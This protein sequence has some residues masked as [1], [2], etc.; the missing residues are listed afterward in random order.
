VSLRPAIAR[1]SRRQEAERRDFALH[2]S[3]ALQPARAT[4]ACP[5]RG[6]KRR[7]P[8]MRSSFVLAIAICAVACTEELAAASY[9]PEEGDLVFQSAPHAPLVDAI[10]GA[11][12]SRW[13]HCGIVVREGDGWAVIEAGNVVRVT[14]FA[15]WVRQARDDE[16]AAYRLRERPEARIAAFIEAAKRFL[17]RPYDARYRMDDEK[18]YCSELVEKAFRAATGRPLGKP[19]RLGDMRWKPYE[20]LIRDLEGGGLPLD[21]EIVSPRALTE[22]PEVTKVY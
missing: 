4:Y 18:I 19:Q 17:G 5:T 2:G 9:S 3:A 1:S 11:T 7:A 10:E 8:G 13:S 15:A 16:F 14:P 22:S 12:E 6:L 21:R 20:T